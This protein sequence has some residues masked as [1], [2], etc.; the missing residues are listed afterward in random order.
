MGG[1]G[2]GSF[3]YVRH[4]ALLICQ[5]DAIAAQ[6]GVAIEATATVKLEAWLAI[7]NHLSSVVNVGS[8]IYWRDVKLLR[9]CLPS[10]CK[11]ITVASSNVVAY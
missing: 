5:N 1:S 10:T 9:A 11:K 6:L 7:M 2:Y 4:L 8:V 3:L